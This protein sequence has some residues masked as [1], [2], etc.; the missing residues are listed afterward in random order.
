[1]IQVVLLAML[2]PQWRCNSL[3]A[4]C[5]VWSQVT[6]CYYK[7]L[8]HWPAAVS[9]CKVHAKGKKKNERWP[10]GTTGHQGIQSLSFISCHMKDNV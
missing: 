6:N 4:L 3:F 5:F 2:C 9:A 10:V 7:P 8:K 1:M